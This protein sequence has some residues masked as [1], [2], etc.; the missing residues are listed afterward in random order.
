MRE[1]KGFSKKADGTYSAKDVE[2]AT[3]IKKQFDEITKLKR[4][5]G[6]FDQKQLDYLKENIKSTFHSRSRK[7]DDKEREN[8][9]VLLKT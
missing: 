5:N 9:S 3:K 7:G 4:Q 1:P 2:F 6:Q 8:G